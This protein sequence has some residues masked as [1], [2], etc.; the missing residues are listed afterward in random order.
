MPAQTRLLTKAA[1]L[2]LLL[3][4][5]VAGYGNNRHEGVNQKQK[6]I[7]TIF[8]IEMVRHGARSHSQSGTAAEDIFGVPAGHLTR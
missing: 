8:V 5:I 1:A 7:K 3:A 4:I 6:D 2:L